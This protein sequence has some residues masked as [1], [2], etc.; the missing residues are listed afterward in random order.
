MV[1]LTL[2][3]DVD[4]EPATETRLEPVSQS[5]IGSSVSSG[6]W[7]KHVSQK[8]INVCKIHIYLLLLLNANF[9]IISLHKYMVQCV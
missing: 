5:G 1:L 2:S 9:Y 3:E 7:N 8:N 4:S 6:D